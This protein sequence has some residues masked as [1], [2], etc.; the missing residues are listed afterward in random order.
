MKA[1]FQTVLLAL[2]LTTGAFAADEVKKETT[3]TGEITGVVCSSCKQHVTAMLTK[4]L[5][6]VVNVDVKPG[7]TDDAPKKLILTAK[8]DALTKEA[9][10]K[11]L[12]DYAKNYQILSLVKQ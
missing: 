10:I 4:N 7:A 8:S 3:F 9:A 12:G 1:L 5:E 6:G 2:S 11:A